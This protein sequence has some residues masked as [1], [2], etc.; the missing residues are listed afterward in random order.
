MPATAS[1][2][3]GLVGEYDEVR[4]RVELL[5]QQ[6]KEIVEARRAAEEVESIATLKFEEEKHALEQASRQKQRELE[7]K[8][9]DSLER[10][11]KARD[12][13]EREKRALNHK[14]NATRRALE[15]K[16]EE[17]L[18]RKDEDIADLS[19][20][21]KDF[22]EAMKHLERLH[23]E[24]RMAWQREEEECKRELEN[25]I[26]V[27]K[28]KLR[29]ETDQWKA[30][31]E[32]AEAMAVDATEKL[33]KQAQQM[34]HKDKV[35]ADLQQTIEF[36]NLEREQEKSAYDESAEAAIREQTRSEGDYSRKLQ[37][38]EESYM[39][40]LVQYKQKKSTDLDMLRQKFEKV[41]LNKDNTIQR[42][43]LQLE[44][45]N[46]QVQSL[47]ALSL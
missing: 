19:E 20:K 18:R 44:K 38:M 8:L 25:L 14:V 16:H 5:K 2:G 42:L 1:R 23:E 32:S 13:H 45:V 40:K 35:V 47:N 7:R 26:E 31:A 6:H 22:E 43:Q 33:K 41:L 21:I 12:L 17:D 15:E 3:M 9:K 24:D 30:R 4:R 36:I 11:A 39:R 46:A 29:G 27:D 10:S 28:A 34:A 37:S